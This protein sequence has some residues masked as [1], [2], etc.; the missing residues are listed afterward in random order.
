MVDRPL[1]LVG[2]PIVRVPQVELWEVQNVA[3][4]SLCP[5]PSSARDVESEH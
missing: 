4:H 3:P 1:L 5:P 2:S